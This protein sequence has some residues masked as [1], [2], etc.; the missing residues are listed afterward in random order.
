MAALPNR[1]PWWSASLRGAVA[2]LSWAIG[3]LNA[4]EPSAGEVPPLSADVVIVGATPGG[5]TAAIAA[6]RAG[7]SVLVLE[8]TT[9]IGGLPAN[10]LGATDI[11]TRGST[12]GLFLEFVGRVRRH[13]VETYGVDSAQVRDCSGG[14]HFEPSVGELILK[15]MIAEQP[16]ITV[17]LQR[18]FDA[19]PMHVTRTGLRV[20]E[21]R[22]LNRET[23]QRERVS[24]KVFIDA[25]YE[26]DLAAAAGASYRIGRE[27]QREFNEPMAGQLYKVWD[28]EAS[29]EST[30]FGDNAIQAY[31]YRL[32]LT[33]VAAN[34]VAIGR[35]AD[36][37]REDYISLLGDIEANRQTGAAGAPRQ[38]L[39]WKGVGRVVNMVVLPNGKTDANNQHAAFLS[40]D[41]PEENWP[42]P[43]SNWEWRDHFAQRLHDYS[44][45][46]LWFC[47]NDPELPAD[48]R[49]RCAEWGLAGDEYADNA[50]FPRQVY[51]REGRRIV[52]THL[53]TAHDA[54]PVTAGGRP[55]LHADSITA[56]QYNLDSHAVRKREPGKPHLDGFFAFN[57]APYTVPYGVI[58]PRE[59]DGLLV[60]VAASATHIGFSTLRMEPCWMALGEAAGTAA[61]LAVRDD[62]PV[63]KIDQRALQRDLVRHGAVL[64]YFRDVPPEH[65]DFE[66]IEMLGLRGLLPE[67]NARPNVAPTE[68]ELAH[69]C[70]LLGVQA[71]NIPVAA[72]KTRGGALTALWRMELSR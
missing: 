7:R 51:V 67:W 66:A 55:P 44:L 59:I 17:L 69:C 64:I 14:Y 18:Q 68:E 56:S 23:Q 37:R 11:G 41:L 21:I 48:F 31:N 29:P 34:R 65:L 53:F 45:G 1:S 52:G 38:E 39:D 70:Q 8:R 60:P 25:T 43:T 50:H 19:L 62:V 10:G 5:L 72:R 30:G 12:G 42:W 26:G 15:G 4:A 22:V 9:H 49:A 32:P 13:Y 58:V 36:Y 2:L 46:L 27:D 6:A 47:Q 24:G 3:L 20:G 57:T 16:R 61:G 28:G 35:P 33:R 63:R 40:T 71:G 54:L